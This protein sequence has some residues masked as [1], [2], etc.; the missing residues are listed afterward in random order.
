[1]TMETRQLAI[2]ARVQIKGMPR[3][4]GANDQQKLKLPIDIG[5][6]G[7]LL[8]YLTRQS[9][10]TEL[11]KCKEVV[12]YTEVSPCNVFILRISPSSQALRE[13]D[14]RMK[15]TLKKWENLSN[16]LAGFCASCASDRSRCP[17]ELRERI[18][19]A[20]DSLKVLLSEKAFVILIIFEPRLNNVSWR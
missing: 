14:E 18:V 16:K 7:A 1:M 4:K 2:D 3:I 12:N 9:S 15:V 11:E 20:V 17:P 19:R 8:Q 10:A 13:G 5:H 6:N